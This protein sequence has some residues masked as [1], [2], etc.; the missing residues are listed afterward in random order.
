MRLFFLLFFLTTL[1]GNFAV[2]TIE[3]I[4][5]HQESSLSS[6]ILAN[7]PMIKLPEHF[8]ICSSHYQAHMNT[9]NTHTIFVLYEDENFTIPWLSIG[10]WSENRLWANVMHDSW[11]ILG[12]VQTQDLFEWIH[13]C[14]EIDLVKKTIV[15]SINGKDF[16]IKDVEDMSPSANAGFNIK[17]GIVH[18]SGRDAKEQFYGKLTN[19]Q[20]LSPTSE[21]LSTITKSLCNYWANTTILAWSDMNWKF[22]GENFEEFDTGDL[23]VLPHRMLT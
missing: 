7:E 20:L 21:K 17:L 12:S 8:V 23:F 4:E 3:F 9:K 11:H 15:T 10:I 16:D 1:S 6:A 14:L 19:I 22:S 2:K 5:N 18:H 13:I